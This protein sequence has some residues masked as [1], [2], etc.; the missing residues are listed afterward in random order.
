M[1]QPSWSGYS[2]AHWDGD[3]LVVESNGFRDDGWFDAWQPDDG[4]RQV[5]GSAGEF[6]AH[7]IEVTVNDPKAYT[8]P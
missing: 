2:T 8:A 7:G 4:C 1:D 6:R 5:S 3:T